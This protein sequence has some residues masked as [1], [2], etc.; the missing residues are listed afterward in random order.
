[1]QA[2]GTETG[3]GAAAETAAARRSGQAPCCCAAAHRM[4]VD[5]AVVTASA[6]SLCMWVGG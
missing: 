1:M 2:E 5:A 3:S 6:C 4:S